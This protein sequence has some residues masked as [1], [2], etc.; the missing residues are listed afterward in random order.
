MILR[1][2]PD[3]P[4]TTET[5]L[6]KQG[7]DPTHEQNLGIGFGRLLTMGFQVESHGDDDKSEQ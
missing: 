1:S 7:I 3:H 2:H 6:P 4:V 5:F